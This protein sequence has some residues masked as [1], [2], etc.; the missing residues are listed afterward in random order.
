MLVLLT[1]HYSDHRYHSLSPC[2]VANVAKVNFLCHSLLSSELLFHVIFIPPIQLTMFKGDHVAHRV[3]SGWGTA[4]TNPGWE[5]SSSVW[6]SGKLIQ[7]GFSLIQRHWKINCKRKP[8]FLNVPISVLKSYELFPAHWN[9]AWLPVFISEW[10]Q[11]LFDLKNGNAF[12]NRWWHPSFSK[13][14]S[15]KKWKISFNHSVSDFKITLHI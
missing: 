6:C 5:G 7:A 13:L 11:S 14:F 8:Y 10:L 4:W 15:K 1:L 12:A 2:T 3:L 9:Q